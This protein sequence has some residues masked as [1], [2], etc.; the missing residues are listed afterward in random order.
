[1]FEDKIN[2]DF[3]TNQITLKKIGF[4]DLFKGKW[5]VIEKKENRYLK[6]LKK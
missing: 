5:D 4:I 3:K 6:E 1:M 2:Y